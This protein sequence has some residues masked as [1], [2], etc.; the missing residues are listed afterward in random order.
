MLPKVC[1][2]APTPAEEE[3]QKGEGAGGDQEVGGCLYGAP[4]AGCAS[5]LTPD[6]A[7]D[8]SR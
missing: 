5:P 3:E 4:L 1:L 8:W 2:L 6:F 7:Q